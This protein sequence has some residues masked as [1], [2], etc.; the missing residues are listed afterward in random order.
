MRKNIN[1]IA[2]LVMT[3]ALAASM[4]FSA[5]ATTRVPQ[6]QDPTGNV[7]AA[8]NKTIKVT[9]KVVTDGHT[10]APNASFSFTVVPEAVTEGESRDFNVKD[11]D[12]N[13][14]ITITNIKKGPEGSI[15]ENGVTD[16]TFAP[17][18]LAS[19]YEETFDV[20]FNEDAFDAPG[21]YKYKLTEVQTSKFTKDGNDTTAAYPGMIYD[22]ADETYYIMY[23][24]VSSYKDTV[25]NTD[26]QKVDNVVMV[27][28]NK[29][30]TINSGI[31]TDALVNYYGTNDPN[32]PD[33]EDDGHDLIITKV[34]DG[35]MHVESDKF[36][37]SIQV[38]AD[39]DGE[40]FEIQKYNPDKA[41]DDKW[42][43]VYELVDGTAKS[44]DDVTQGTKY[45]VQ[46]LTAGD[47]V[48]VKETNGNS[49][50]YDITYAVD[51]ASKVV[52][53]TAY[54]GKLDDTKAVAV[55][56]SEDGHTLTITNT[57]NEVTPTGVVMDVAPYALM[58]ALAGGAAATFL[59]KKE[60]FED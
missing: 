30:G 36:T 21:V 14:D 16:A 52:E 57:R 10:Y 58:V 56:V 2:T 42:E 54:N 15:A 31:K 18:T 55:K 29:N 48:S 47:V 53:Q 8:S 9:K 27:K 13:K 11:G 3:G 44:F 7:M 50:G 12:S 49:Q 33:T 45:R 38:D 59:R 4:S 25:T 6:P 28:S 20:T 19:V 24:F 17:T 35:N 1:K 40:H 46:G 26:K 37:F 23:A 43:S 34:I 51:D 41:G 60:S 39:A 5:F 22:G 32:T